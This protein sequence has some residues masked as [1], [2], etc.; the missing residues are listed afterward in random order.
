MLVSW[1]KQWRVLVASMVVLKPPS[2]DE[3]DLVIPEFAIP[4]VYSDVL[5]K[6]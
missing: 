3:P 4:L 1:Q 6:L 5:N 2:K